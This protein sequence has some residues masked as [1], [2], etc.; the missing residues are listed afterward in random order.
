MQYGESL[1][2]L[3]R[4][5]DGHP[6]DAILLMC[7]KPEAISAGLPILRQAFAGPIGGYANIGYTRNP[8]FGSQRGVQW[9]TIDQETYPPDRYAGFARAWLDFGAQI[10][11]GCCATGPAHIEAVASVLKERGH[12]AAVVS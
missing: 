2:D 7:S 9:H 11:G 1:A 12:R 10:V 8:E 5:L 4:A 6:I 3:A